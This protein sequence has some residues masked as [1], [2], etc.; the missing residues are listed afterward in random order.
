MDIIKK[1]RHIDYTGKNFG[2]TEV[3]RFSHADSG[4]NAYWVCKCWRC[5]SEYTTSIHNLKRAKTCVCKKCK[6][7]L[8]RESKLVHEKTNTRLFTIWMNMKD[9]CY[10]NTSKSYS[11]YGGRGI[12]ICQEWLDDFMNFYNWAMANGYRDDL[13]IERKDVNGNYC[14][15]N[16]SWATMKEQE[17]NRRN[18]VFYEINGIKCTL[19][20]WCD[21]YNMDYK[22][23]RER[24]KK[25]MDIVDALT[26]PKQKPF[27]MKKIYTKKNNPELLNQ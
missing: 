25:G 27:G 4:G 18:S 9:R 19:S 15:E 20:E 21:K 12:T 22:L 11:D 3:L 16:C 26:I 13:T 10:R 23:V 8:L 6:N 2:G 7:V 5:K 1:S 17:N 14:P 24:V